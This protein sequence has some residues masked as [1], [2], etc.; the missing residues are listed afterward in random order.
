MRIAG[1]T[2][3]VRGIALLAVAGVV[4]I[5]LG[6]HGWSG[7][8]NG[9]PSSLAGPQ[10]SPSVKARPS[11]APSAGPTSAPTQGPRAAGSPTSSA[12]PAPGAKLSAQSYAQYAY[13]LWPGPE[14]QAAKTA[15]TGLTI[16]VHRSGSGIT[17]AAGVAGQSKP[18][19]RSYPTGAKVYV[20][21]ASLGDDSNNTDFN[22]GD[23]GIVV[24]D[25]QG[26]IVQ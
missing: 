10:A 19:N 5:V 4:G 24:T 17:V 9:L 15:A 21:E 25:S 1:E 3:G 6:V 16:N 26:R 11:Q 7:R 13:Q 18:V 2:V 12:S 22:L 14:S 8:H 23:D 20:I